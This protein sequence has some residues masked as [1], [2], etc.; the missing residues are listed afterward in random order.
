MICAPVAWFR[1]ASTT[2]R[3]RDLA[4]KLAHLGKMMEG[5]TFLLSS[6]IVLVGPVFKVANSGFCRKPVTRVLA[7]TS[8]SVM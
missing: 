5:R 6:W 8:L 7:A 3:E 1:P 4:P 2:P